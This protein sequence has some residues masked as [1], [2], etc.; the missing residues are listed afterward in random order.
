M[1]QK[2]PITLAVPANIPTDPV[3]VAGAFTWLVTQLQ[4]WIKLVANQLNTTPTLPSGNAGGVVAYTSATN[5]TSSPTLGQNELVLGGGS[6]GTPMTPVSLGTS[7]QVL[8]GNASGA[9]S[10][11]AVQNADLAN[12]SV[13]LNGHALS[14][15]GTL[16]LAQSDITSDPLAVAHGGTGTSATGTALDNIGPFTTN[17]FTRRTGAGT[18][19]VDA[20]GQLQAT[21]TNDNA[22]SGRL[23]EFVSAQVLYANR[24]TITTNN[25]AQNLTSISLTAG[26]WDV[27]GSVY[28]SLNSATVTVYRA[29]FNSAS[30][31]L[32]DNT[33]SVV[34]GPDSGAGDQGAAVPP[35]RFSLAATTTIYLVVQSTFSAGNPQ[36]SGL[37]QARRA[38]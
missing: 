28:F 4:L 22:S 35:F 18:Y 29:G 15:G 33:Q 1:T 12:A 13:T 31:T 9:P 30:A 21:A 20:P 23:G 36:A 37:I 10:W 16:T 2:I 14:L 17:G 7:T 6:S 11:S 8:H 5:L 3:G 34:L 19:T 26:D 32:P 24:I 27:F 38:R 25:T